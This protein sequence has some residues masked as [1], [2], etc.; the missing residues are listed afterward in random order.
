MTGC[1]PQGGGVVVLA[2]G[3][4]S[5]GD[6][7][8]GPLL[9]ERLRRWL[10][11]RDSPPR[12][13]LVEAFQFQPEHAL[14]LAGHHLALFVDAAAAGPAPYDFTAVSPQ[15]D[16]SYS[17]HAMTPGA[18]LHAYEQVYDASPPHAWQLAIR[19][20][21]FELGAPVATPV[22]EY[23]A[24]AEGL[25]KRLCLHRQAEYWQAQIRAFDAEP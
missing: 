4:P 1:H 13:T 18:V 22:L 24:A 21:A 25:V 16:A 5:R 20:D 6:D 9:L 8:V 3:N 15:R 12:V 7:A 23:L 17:S 10:H 11:E 14:D 2:C 19:G